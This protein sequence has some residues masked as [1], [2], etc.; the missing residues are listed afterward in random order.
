MKNRIS[1]CVNVYK[2]RK[3]FYRW[4]TKRFVVLR[5]LFCK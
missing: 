1:F 5:F 4:T 2:N 3:T